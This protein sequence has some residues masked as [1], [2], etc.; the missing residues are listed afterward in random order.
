MS[1]EINWGKYVGLV[2]FSIFLGFTQASVAFYLR[3]NLGIEGDPFPLRNHPE[4]PLGAFS[5][6][7]SY[8]EITTLFMIIITS[9]MC[10]QRPLYRFLVFTFILGFC[11]MSYYVFLRLFSGWPGSLMSFDI[12]FLFPSLWIA[13]VLATI[14]LAFTMASASGILLYAARNK[15]LRSPELLEWLLVF[16][17]GMIVMYAF[18][19]VELTERSQLPDFSWWVFWIGY[20][21][22]LS[23]LFSYLVQVIRQSRMRFF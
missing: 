23:G 13:P 14:I 15:S 8:R 6:I 16:S 21:L 19:S 12:I 5:Q 22:G 7:E 3:K 1:H 11:V 18:L 4:S 10:S 20:V 17:G 9:L 2:L